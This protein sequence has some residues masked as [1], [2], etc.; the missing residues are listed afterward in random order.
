MV[1]KFRPSTAEAGRAGDARVRRGLLL[2]QALKNS[3]NAKPR[4]QGRVQRYQGFPC[5]S[6]KITFDEWVTQSRAL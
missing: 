2:I 1:K 4:D 5:V 6:G 3:P